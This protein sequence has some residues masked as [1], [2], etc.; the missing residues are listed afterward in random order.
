[1]TSDQFRNSALALPGAVE[2]QHMNHPDFRIGGKIFAS[3]GYPDEIS[4]MVKLT[5][6]QQLEFITKSPEVFNP[7]AGAWGLR[8]ATNVHLPLA[9]TSEIRSALKIA[10]ENVQQKLK[11]K[12]V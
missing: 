9:K 4:A 7:C 6:E 11:K 3:L 5:P 10:H 1:M 12:K 2:S 8:G